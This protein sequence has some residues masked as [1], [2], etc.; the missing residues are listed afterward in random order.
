VILL[1]ILAPNTIS[2]VLDHFEGVFD[3]LY[4]LQGSFPGLG[5]NDVVS[6]IDRA[7]PESMRNLPLDLIRA[8]RGA[9]MF[10]MTLLSA[11]APLGPFPALLGLWFDDVTRRGFGRIGGVLFGSD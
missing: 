5:G 11:D 8:E 6:G 1:A 10:G 4:L 2:N 9:F 7:A 3:Q